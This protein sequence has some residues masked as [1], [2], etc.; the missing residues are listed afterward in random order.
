VGDY[1]QIIAD[2][3]ATEAEAPALG[4]SVVAW[5][6]GA[7]IIEAVPT[8]CVLSTE[9]GYPPGPRYIAA[10]TGPGERLHSLRTNGLAVITTRSVFHPIQG[11]LGPVACPRCG[12]TVEL[13]DPATGQAAHQ[14][15]RFSDA[16]STWMT[17]GPCEVACPHCGQAAGFNDWHWASDWP[18]AVGFLG[19]KFWNWPPL[20]ESF[21]AQLASQLGHRVVVT[22]GKL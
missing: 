2:T 13:E 21:I 15:E 8:D 5:L 10:V 20:K 16:L 6:A 3:E 7:G 14:W 18:F 1:F 22:R 19:F 17:G 11:E 4:A 9:P 12:Q